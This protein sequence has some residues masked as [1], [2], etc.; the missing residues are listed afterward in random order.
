MSH[1]TKPDYF[2]LITRGLGYLKR[3]RQVPIERAKPYWAATVVPLDPVTLKL[4]SA[5]DCRVCGDDAIAFI[6]QLGQEPSARNK[7]PSMFARES[8]EKIVILPTKR[9]IIYQPL[10]I[11]LLA[12]QTPD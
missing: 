2:N 3:I 8:S 1:S 6:E 7:G 9:T 10:S 4:G 11:L 12:A 5:I